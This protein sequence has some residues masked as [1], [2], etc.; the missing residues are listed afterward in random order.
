MTHHITKS[1]KVN[2]PSEEI[3]KVLEDFSSVEK[4]A[5]TIQSSPI[6]GDIKTG[7]GAKRLCTFKDGSSL[8]EEITEFHE[9]KGYK[10][11][12]SEHS[13]PLKFMNSE[14]GVRKIDANQSEL[15]M[16]CDFEVKGGPLGWLLGTLLMGPMMKSVFT[17]LMS[18]LAH[19]TATGEEI[20]E[21]LPSKET[22]SKVLTA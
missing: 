12:L 17:K 15:Y 8:V 10:M 22:L 11:A 3:W 7:L 2:V 16:N 5:T 6:K 14:M 1:L 21:K 20:G 19:Y 9:G 18:G 4:F 13:L